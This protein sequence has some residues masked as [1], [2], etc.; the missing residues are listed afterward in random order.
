MDQARRH[1]LDALADLAERHP[2]EQLRATRFADFIQAHPDCAH[3]SLQDGHLTGSVWL[4][5]PS[6]ERVL[7]THHRK[8][9]RWLQLGGH[10]DG[11]LDLAAAALREAR[12]ESGLAQLRL[13]DGQLFAID[14]HCIPARGSEPA[15][16]HFDHCYVVVAEGDLTPV[17]SEESKALQWWPISELTQWPEPFLQRM[18]TRWLQRRP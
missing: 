13:L 5:D 4:V 15:H 9:D 14:D 6:G 18:A 1:L 7:L 10:A 2:E 17:L 12:E 8:L 11:D 3:R 16:T